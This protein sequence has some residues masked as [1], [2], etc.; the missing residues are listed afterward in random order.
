MLVSSAEYNLVNFGYKLT[1]T[2]VGS[3]CWQQHSQPVF[4]CVLHVCTLCTIF[5]IN[6]MGQSTCL[7][8]GVCTVSLCGISPRQVAHRGERTRGQLG[9]P[10]QLTLE[11]MFINSILYTCAWMT[12]PISSSSAPQCE[13]THT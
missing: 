5:I 8:H 13:F 10:R 1:G 6:I 7:T 12:G 11:T 3:G 9:C 2:R 4:N